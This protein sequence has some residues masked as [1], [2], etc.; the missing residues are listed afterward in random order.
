MVNQS[1]NAIQRHRSCGFA[2]EIEICNELIFGCAL[3]GKC[4]VD[5]R[6]CFV[7]PFA[8]Q[9]RLTYF[10]RQLVAPENR[11]EMLAFVELS[12][13]NERMAHTRIVSKQYLST[14]FTDSHT[15]RTWRECSFIEGDRDADGHLAHVIFTT[16]S[17]QDVKGKELEAM[18][19]IRNEMEITGALSRDY[20]DVVLLDLAN[21]TAVTI[22][23]RGIMIAEDQRTLRRSYQDTWDT[24]ISKYV[25]EEDKPA[26]Y[27]AIGVE[28]VKRALEHS[29]EY[30][31]S[32]RVIADETGVHH[33]QASFLRFYS[34]NHTESQL[35]LGFRCVDAIVEE[36]R[37]N[38]AIQENYPSAR[39]IL[40]DEIGIAGPYPAPGITRKQKEEFQAKLK[41][42]GV[43][44]V[45]SGN[46]GCGLCTPKETGS[47][48]AAEY[49]GIPSVM[50][51]GPGFVDQARYTAL[52][53]L[54][55]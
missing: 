3:N 41:E 24:Y 15:G 29:D 27:A 5:V 26:L 13:L 4:S 46:G 53:L 22:K 11:E 43:D 30:S 37:K 42:M 10:C 36:E 39:V 14:L 28:T 23:R 55:E 21:D 8:G 40:L 19:R 49:L 33:Y 25:L 12:T 17:I 45:I 2:G 50:I 1:G 44:A 32:Y 6:A 31:C 48:I 51:A 34:R 7:N 38:A 47:C 52:I 35:I 54:T 18:E 16:K 20:P 9:D